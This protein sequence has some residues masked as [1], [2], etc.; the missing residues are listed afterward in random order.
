ME[1]IEKK[2]LTIIEVVSYKHSIFPNVRP[3]MNVSRYIAYY[4]NNKELHG[5]T[6]SNRWLCGGADGGIVIGLVGDKE[7]HVDTS[8][9]EDRRLRSLL[10][11]IEGAKL[12]EKHERQEYVDDPYGRLVPSGKVM[13]QTWDIS[14]VIS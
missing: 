8:N 6:I 7:L 1:K 3:K 12:V 11:R 9:V 4:P 2:D 14:E 13:A 10:T 5:K